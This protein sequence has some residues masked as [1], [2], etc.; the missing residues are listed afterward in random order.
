[1]RAHSLGLAPYCWLA[2][3]LEAVLGRVIGAELPDVFFKVLCSL[4]EM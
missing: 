4:G 2:D 1:M 3:D